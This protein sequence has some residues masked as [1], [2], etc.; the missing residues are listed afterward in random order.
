MSL[1]GPK[2]YFFRLPKIEESDESYYDH[3]DEDFDKKKEEIHTALLGYLE[4]FETNPYIGFEPNNDLPKI[5]LDHTRDN[6]FAHR[7]IIKLGKLLAPLRAVVPTW[8]TRDSQGSEYNFGFSGKRLHN[9]GRYSNA[10][11]CGLIDMFFG[12]GYDIRTYSR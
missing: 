12:Q 11:T 4:Y 5:P 3:K 7:Y 6:E 9:V 10:Y 2:L 8:E 1:L